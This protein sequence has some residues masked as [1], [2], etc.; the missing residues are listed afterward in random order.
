MIEDLPGANIARGMMTSVRTLF[1]ALS[2][3]VPQ[4]QDED[5]VRHIGRD[6]QPSRD[7]PYKIKFR[8]KIDIFRITNFKNISILEKST[9]AKLTYRF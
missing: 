8:L 1:R 2:F 5:F 7:Q 3:R 4:R 6:P 9:K